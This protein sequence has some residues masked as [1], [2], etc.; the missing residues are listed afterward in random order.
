MALSR[1]AFVARAL[2]AGLALHIGDV[3]VSP[4]A[5]SAAPAPPTL[6]AG[7]AL[8]SSTVR[9]LWTAVAEADAYRV[10]RDD[11]LIVEQPGTL[12]EDNSLA[13]TTTY[14]YEV[15]SVSAGIESPR[16]A[17]VVVVTQQQDPTT[18]PT[19]PTNLRASSIT[20]SS[21]RLTW[22]RSTSVAKITGYRI[23]RGPAGAPLGDLVQIATTDG[24]TSYTASKLFANRTYQFAVRAVDVAGHLG[25]AASIVITTRTSNDTGVPS[26]PS[27]S[28]VTVRNYC[29][30]RLDVTW[31]SSNSSDVAGYRVYRNDALIATV[32]EPLRKTYS[33]NGLTPSTAYT[34]KIAAVDSA[35]NVSAL[36][37]GRTGTTS[38]EGTILVT[39]G[40]YVVQTDRTSARVL[41]W[42]N[43]PAP[44]TVDYGIGTISASVY[45]PTPRLQHAMLLGGL[46]PGTEYGYQVR[47]G[48][49]MFGG[50][51]F[52]TA[53]SP[54]TAFTFAAVGDFGGG[55]GQE[56]RIAN[57]IAASSAQFVQT[58][59]DNVYPDA[60][61]PDP[62]HFYS[63]F[64]NRFYKQYGPVIRTRTFFAANGN[65]EYYGDGAA[66]RN[67]WTPNNQRWYSYEWGDVHV[68]V[69][70]SEQP[71][72]AG[73]P[74][75]AF[76]NADLAA[77]TTAWKIC[78][79]HRPPYS[80]TTSSSSSQTVLT[81][82]TPLLEQ[83]GVTLCL[84]GNSHNYERSYPLRAGAIDQTGVTYVVTGGGGNGL[85]TFQMS[86]PFWS[87]YREA[88]FEY[89][90]C[91]VSPTQLVFNAYS[92]YGE[93]FDSTTW[94]K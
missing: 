86:Q 82:L 28:S 92:E 56:T 37:S 15:A 61:D 52:T 90:Q 3:V 62:E 59:G 43:T 63:D 39:R 12:L 18:P 8:T 94:A 48:N 33:D 83:Y 16:S 26:A 60:Q 80:S 72:G 74:Q 45:D 20:S 49:A 41:W 38:A 91:S 31:G 75:R 29:S 2:A 1:R 89:V 71:L 19:A 73:S 69:V 81:N 10:Y 30:N 40:P 9:L 53:A 84:S 64:D 46:A 50:C 42:T 88:R 25:P 13:P 6:L 11:Q 51:R 22:T 66:A 35:G 32:E 57:L 23:L 78:V 47:S 17:P 21:V 44:S 14:R 36:T 4:P 54:G 79:V 70:D 67:L 7:Q 65:K 85:N 55:S 5:A 68:L 34:Y 76:V 93:L 27:S 77:A 58:V 24:G 87:A